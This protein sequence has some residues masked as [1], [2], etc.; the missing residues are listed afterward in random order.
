MKSDD[1]PTG[2]KPSM[3]KRAS[4][5]K[6]KMSLSAKKIK[7]QAKARMT[8]QGEIKNAI[9]TLNQLAVPDYAVLANTERKIPLRILQNAAGLAFLTEV[10]A[11]FL[12]SGKGGTGI[13]IRRLSGGGWSGPSCF[14]FAGVGAGL[15]AGV[16]KT[17]TIVVLNTPAACEVFGSKGQIKL[18]ADLEITAGPIGREV[19]GAARLGGEKTVASSYSYSHSKGLYAGFSIDGTGLVCKGDVNTEFYGAEVSPADILSGRAEPPQIDQLRELYA[20]LDRL[21]KA[22]SS[23][24]AGE[25]GAAASNAVGGAKKAAAKAAV[26]M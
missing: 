13:V 24:I 14:G 7:E 1:I 26:G 10:K 8:M 19:G 18:G 11:G 25:V 16:S 20:L 3:K 12:F 15:M 6:A 5:M 17:N 22:S 4:A 2:R 23:D 9:E 21:G